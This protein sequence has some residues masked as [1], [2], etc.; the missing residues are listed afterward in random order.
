MSTSSVTG[1]G[2]TTS[3]TQFV[4]NEFESDRNESGFEENQTVSRFGE[5]SRVND[6]M[7][8][9]VVTYVKHPVSFHL[10]SVTARSSALAR[11]WRER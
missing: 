7:P 2:R 10:V 8:T 4:I 3:S 6:D 5:L 11:S 9:R 1:P